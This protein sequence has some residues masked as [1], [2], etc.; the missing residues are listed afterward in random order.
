[1]EI[2]Q[3]FCAV[4][5][6]AI[7]IPK[8][9]VVAAILFL[10][11]S[12]LKVNAQS[13]MM[14]DVFSSMPD[15]ILPYLSTNNRLDMIDF[16]VMNMKSE[17]V[18]MFD[19]KSEMKIL[20]NDYLQLSL[21]EATLVEMKLKK[22]DK[23]LA[24]SSEYIV[25]VVKTFGVEPKHSIVKTY[26]SKWTPLGEIALGQY[27]KFLVSWKDDVSDESLDF[28]GFLNNNVSIVAS[29][30][31]DDNSMLLTPFLYSL[32]NDEKTKIEEKFTLK[33]F[34]IKL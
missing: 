30:C 15:S 25:Y 26:T 32:T 22:A 5:R 29:L 28:K 27:L 34:K 23:L 1:M 12:P 11:L 33:T 2:L 4:R 17:V 8:S 10:F 14:S 24:D 6:K 31:S 7:A 9:V 16:S 3:S 19:E 13:L 21:N 20:G 18:N